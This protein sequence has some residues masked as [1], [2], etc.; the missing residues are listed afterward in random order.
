MAP[1]PLSNQELQ[2]YRGAHSADGLTGLLDHLDLQGL[3]A[4]GPL[5]LEGEAGGATLEVLRAAETNLANAIENLNLQDL[6]DMFNN[7]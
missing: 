3:G 1:E 2:G 5:G 6:H 4:Q 7:R